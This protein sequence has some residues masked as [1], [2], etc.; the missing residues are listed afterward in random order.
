VSK[1]KK[2]ELAT[3]DISTCYSEVHKVFGAISYID[4]EKLPHTCWGLTSARR[5]PSDISELCCQADADK[6][7][8]NESLLSRHQR[9]NGP[10]W[11]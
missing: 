9:S 11:M 4:S 3:S 5:A 6:T 2:R 7:W 10:S 1:K 8:V